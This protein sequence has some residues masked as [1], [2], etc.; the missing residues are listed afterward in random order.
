MSENEPR[1]D[2]F[3]PSQDESE[4]LEF[5][6]QL[7]LDSILETAHGTTTGSADAPQPATPRRLPFALYIAAAA[8]AAGL[9]MTLLSET[10]SDPR[11]TIAG[12]SETKVAM[13]SAS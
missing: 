11:V 3:D 8:V 7:A 1:I 9:F 10:W 4:R 13:G 6:R 5:G 12:K 2:G